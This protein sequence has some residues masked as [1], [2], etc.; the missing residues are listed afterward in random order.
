MQGRIVQECLEQKSLFVL[1]L[2]LTL[3]H[4][5]TKEGRLKYDNGVSVHGRQEFLNVL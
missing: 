5:L 4:N 2:G 3:H 1:F